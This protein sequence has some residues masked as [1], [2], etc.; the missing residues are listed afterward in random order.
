LYWGNNSEDFQFQQNN[1]LQSEMIDVGDDA[2]PAF[3]DED[4]DGDLDLFVG[5]YITDAA[6]GTIW[7]F[8]NTGTPI[9]PVFTLVTKDY[10]NLSVQNLANIKPSFVDVNADGKKDLIFSAT[11]ISDGQTGIFYL[12]NSS[13]AMQLNGSIQSL[14]FNFLW[15]ERVTFTDYDS[16]G[17]MDI[18]KGTYYGAIQLWLNSGGFQ[19]N[20]S[21]KLDYLGSGTNRTNPVTAVADLNNDGK[22]DLLIGNADGY[23]SIVDDYRSPVLSPIII[24]I[25]NPVTEEFE[26]VK[27]A[28]RLFPTV[29]RLFG[30]SSP[31]PSRPPPRW[32]WASAAPRA[33]PS[34][35]RA[36][37]RKTSSWARRTPMPTTCG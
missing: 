30:T 34:A 12:E 26:S 7:Y 8:E 6:Q 16:D 21:D 25:L 32:H 37:W 14:S 20:L 13:T 15:D 33:S 24:D 9:A 27:L 2:V 3:A 28:G 18:I 36:R 35:A 23:L 11:K 29:A 10:L 5:S 1:F 22:Q 17:D 31:P 4:G 19:F